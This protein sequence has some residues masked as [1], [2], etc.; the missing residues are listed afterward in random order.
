MMLKFKKK[1]ELHFGRYS[2]DTDSR[3][4]LVG[5]FRLMYD[6]EKENI[7]FWMKLKLYDSEIAKLYNLIFD[8]HSDRFL[9]TRYKPS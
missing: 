3:L 4:V 6:S 7:S 2:I 1:V 8:T 9:Q 5:V